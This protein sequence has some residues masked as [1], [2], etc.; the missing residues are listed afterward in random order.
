MLQS[1]VDFPILDLG[2][3]MADLVDSTLFVA[4]SSLAVLVV[5]AELA[6]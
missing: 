5:P 1:M 6:E 2:L 4:D 3:Q